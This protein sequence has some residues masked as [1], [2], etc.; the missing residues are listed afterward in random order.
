M[1]YELEALR[2]VTGDTVRPGGYELTQR[3]VEFCGLE[4]G[5]RLLDVG[6]GSGAS[7]EFLIEKFKLDAMGI[8]PSAEMLAL[9]LQRCA[10]LPI[11]RG[12][13]EKLDFAGESIDAVL[14]ECSLSHY[15]DMHQALR[16][17]HRVLSANGRLIVSDIYIRGDRFQNEAFDHRSSVMKPEIVLRHLK[18]HGFEVILFED[19]T[20]KLIQLNIDIIM[21]Y[22]SVEKLLEEARKRHIACDV[23][24]GGHRC[25]L[26]YYLLA[27]Q[28]NA[29]A[30]IA[31]DACHTERQQT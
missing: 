15:A 20:D 23:L 10:G 7:V 8:D 9:G 25:Q 26:G 28:K 2:A 6:C 12:S 1:L 22:G 16:E 4:A 14:S 19:H 29:T 13:A 21:K 5:S 3:A 30:A 31:A 11:F 18:A 17:F 27:A 24:E